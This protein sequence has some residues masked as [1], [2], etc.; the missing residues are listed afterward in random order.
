MLLC[1]LF[2][3][4][5]DGS[6]AIVHVPD[7]LVHDSRTYSIDLRVHPDNT[8]YFKVNWDSNDY[9]NSSNSCGSGA[10]FSVYRGCLCDI[11]VI[12]SSVISSL[13]TESEIISQLH[14][15]AHDPESLGSYTRAT[16]TG[17][18]EVW[19]KNGSYDK[20]TIFR[21]HSYKGKELY[22]KNMQS[23]VKINGATQFSFRNP[24]SFMNIAQREGRDASFETDAILKN[25]FY[26]DNVGPFLA[27]R[28]I[29]RF[30]VSNP[31]PRYIESVANGM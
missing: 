16:N 15:G 19:H 22:L 7:L 4:N 9:P 31:S 13:P 6:V 20:E 30:G 28:L 2:S 27:L 17:S 21:I 5:E 23:T 26:H 18:F 14:I 25:Y 10:C 11:D 8:N 24:P 29:Q 3:V 1:E 12:E